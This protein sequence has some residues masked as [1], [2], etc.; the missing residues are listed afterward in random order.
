METTE[1]NRIELS[2]ELHGF[3]PG[4]QGSQV[5]AYK[6]VGPVAVVAISTKHAVEFEEDEDG[7]DWGITTNLNREDAIALRDFLTKQIRNSR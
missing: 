1:S 3:Y 2:D 6:P 4:N 7:W 5:V